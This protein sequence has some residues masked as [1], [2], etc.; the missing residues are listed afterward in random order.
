MPEHKIVN[1]KKVTMTA[2]QEATRKAESD[3]IQATLKA[4]KL[5]PTKHPLNSFQ[6][7][8][9]LEQ[10]GLG[11]AKVDAAIDTVESDQNERITA[12]CRFRHATSYRR[13]HPLLVSLV[14]PLGKTP[15]QIDTEWMA[16]VNLK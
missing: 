16:A 3:A 6:F 13:D 14:A 7:F 9:F 4:A 5:D 10:L 1:G 8:T 2:D 15:A 12:R 11:E